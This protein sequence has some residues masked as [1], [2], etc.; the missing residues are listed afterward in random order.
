MAGP[1]CGNGALGSV[2]IYAGKD[3][4]QSREEY[5]QEWVGVLEERQ[6][7]EGPNSRAALRYAL[8]MQDGELPVYAANVVDLLQPLVGRRVTVR[9]KV[10]DMSSEGFAREL[11]VG[12]IKAEPE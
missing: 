2:E 5:E 1:A 6:T 9:G 8:V 3:W 10:V 11:W 4:Y 12:T 7:I